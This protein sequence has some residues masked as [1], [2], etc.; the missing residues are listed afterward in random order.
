MSLETPDKIRSLQRKLYCKAKAEPA[1]R[2]ERDPVA[3]VAKIGDREPSRSIA[4]C[5][6]LKAC[7]LPV[8]G[9]HELS[10]DGEHL[11]FTHR[12]RCCGRCPLRL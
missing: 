3:A 11:R 10:Q 8:G 1:F 12:A 5:A 9:R 4:Q 6:V 7:Q 2:F